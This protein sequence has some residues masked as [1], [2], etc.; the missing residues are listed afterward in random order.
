MYPEILSEITLK[1]VSLK[2]PSL[3]FVSEMV[4]KQPYQTAIQNIA[5]QFNIEET[6]E[7]NYD[8]AFFYYLVK[9]EWKWE[10]ALSMIGKYALLSR[11]SK[12]SKRS[13]LTT[14]SSDLTEDEINLIEILSHEGFK[15]I[16]KVSLEMHVDLN[17]PNSTETH[18]YQALFTNQ[19]LPW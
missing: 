10:L 6:T 9:G 1:Y 11:L 7:I 14:D 8:V 3:A 2:K 16:D 19:E 5:R 18:L 17:L 12:T 4:M 15:F 13:P